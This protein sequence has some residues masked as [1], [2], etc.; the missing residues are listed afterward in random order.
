[1]CHTRYILLLHLMMVEET[2]SKLYYLET[3]TIQNWKTKP[4]FL[5]SIICITVSDLFM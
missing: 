4:F 2:F 1:M 3:K 5:P